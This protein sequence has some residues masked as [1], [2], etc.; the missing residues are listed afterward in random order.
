MN[1]SDDL[2]QQMKIAMDTCETTKQTM[3]FVFGQ[4]GCPCGHTPSNYDGFIL[5]TPK[6]LVTPPG[7]NPQLPHADD[8]CSSCLVVLIHLNDNQEPTR[9]AK[10]D[11]SKDYPTGI[12]VTCD[13]CN[14]EEMLPD[15][16]FR[17]GVHVTNENWHCD[18]KSPHQP[19]DFEGGLATAFGE[20][21]EKDAPDSCDS[22]CGKHLA[23]AG[24]G[25]LC[26]P[27]LIHRGPGNSTTAKDSRYM[28]FF[29]LKPMYKNT[30]ESGSQYHRYN[31]DLQIHAPCILFNKFQRVKRIYEKSGCSLEGYFSAFLGNTNAS[32][33]LEN[34][35]LRERNEQL[36][37]MLNK[38]GITVSPTVMTK[39]NGAFASSMKVSSRGKRSKSHDQDKNDHPSRKCRV[40]DCTKYWQTRCDG[41]CR[42]H[43]TERRNRP[44]VK[45]LLQP[46][47]EVEAKEEGQSLV[48]ETDT[49]K[50]DEMEEIKTVGEDEQGNTKPADSQ[51]TEQQA[52]G[53]P[54]GW[55][56]ERIPRRKGSCRDTYYY[57][58]VEQYQFRSSKFIYFRVCTGGGGDICV[59]VIFSFDIC[60]MRAR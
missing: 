17:R 40:M 37:D 39:T 36:E 13:R 26:L 38:A 55:T 34:A 20:L 16:D 48:E 35:Q 19:Y 21:L 22:Y 43:F 10:Y 53:V 49:G 31:P 57:S 15:C 50:T 23:K 32:L 27:Q 44:A 24:S 30:K 59:Q 11:S 1:V 33:M 41:Y 9:V 29:T 7:S 4:M 58:P 6:V 12:T 47:E 45:D 56:M 46:E 2:L 42:A 3:K 54:D 5:D 28:L 51:I 14:R 8:H 18:C 52:H 60:I 25:V